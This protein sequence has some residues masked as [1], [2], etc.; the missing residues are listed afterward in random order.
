MEKYTFFALLILAT[1]F[2]ACAPKSKPEDPAVWEKVKIDLNRL[3]ENGLAGP[4]DGKV[5]VNYEFCIP[6]GESNWREVQ[7]TD[8]TAQIQTGKGRIGC[9]ADQWLVIGSTRQKNHRR[10]LYELAA[11]AYVKEIREVFYE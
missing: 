9:K 2:V 4:P 8:G 6:A 5:A 11:L 1:E 7:K 10:V 3:D